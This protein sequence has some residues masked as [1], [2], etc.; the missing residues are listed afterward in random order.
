M[1][2][3]YKSFASFAVLALAALIL[4]AG[5]LLVPQK[6]TAASFLTLTYPSPDRSESLL[7]VCGG[8]TAVLDPSEDDEEQLSVILHDRRI[9]KIDFV[10]TTK[11]H[12]TISS[13]AG[14]PAGETINLGD[15]PD[16][17]PIGEALLVMKSGVPV[18]RHGKTVFDVLPLT[19]SHPLL[20]G[21]SVLVSDGEK[22]RVQPDG[23]RWE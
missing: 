16:G 7:L 10:L 23:S 19:N 21:A 15:C 8:V 2:M 1:K 11:S 6:K 18:L 22:I 4:T 17:I 5:A 12:E 3:P 14:I 9:R 20:R 13:V